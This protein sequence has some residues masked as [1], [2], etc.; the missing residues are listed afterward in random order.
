MKLHSLRIENLR[1]FCDE[2]I[3]F[4]DYT[5]F[6]GANGSGKSTVLT[7]LNIFFREKAG[8]ATNLTQLHRE[9]F[10]AQ[11]T[12]KPIRITLTFV[13]LSA[14]A[15]ADFDAYVRQ[16]KLVV[17]AEA[18]WDASLGYAEVRQVGERM[19]IPQF[20]E[21][22]LAVARNAKKAELEAAYITS[23][24]SVG[25]TKPYG[26]KDKAVETLNAYEASRPE[27]CKPIPSPTDF[28]GYTGGEYLLNKYL[29]WV[30]V[31]AVKDAAEEEAEAKD[32]S[33]SR[34]LQR[35]AGGK[36]TF[37]TDLPALRE[38]MRAEYDGIVTKNQQHL[39]G[40]SRALRQRIQKWAHPGAS[41]SVGFEPNEKS[42]QVSK[43]PAL[44]KAGESGFSGAVS[45]FGHG[46]QRCFLI[47]I[48]QELATASGGSGPRLILGIEEPELYQHPPQARHLADVLRELSQGNTQIVA[49]THSPH[50]ISGSD[51]KS[52]RLV[53]RRPNRTDACVTAVDID[54]IGAVLSAARGKPEGRP[55]AVLAK[56]GQS[57]QPSL[58]EMFFTPVAVFVEGLEDVAYITAYLGVTNQ[59]DAFR[60][61]GCH[62]IPTDK[63]SRMMHPLAIAKQLDIP[64]FV[65]F[66]AD[67]N[68]MKPEPR[69][70]AENDN[71]ALL[72]LLGYKGEDP[73]PQATLWKADLVMWAESITSVVRSEMGGGPAYLA[74]EEEVKRL[75]D[76][77]GSGD[78][79]KNSV[80]IGYTVGE[81]YLRGHRSP[82]L[83][84]LLES[85]ITFAQSKSAAAANDADVPQVGDADAPRKNDVA[86]QVRN[87][88]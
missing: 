24:N 20:S 5:S 58:N 37:D 87:S 26:S 50:F 41:M 7:A 15:F 79:G 61:L 67:A 31:P 53:R 54:A 18:T 2:T 47:A 1:A 48:L 28:Y 9:D 27:L 55:P 39:D 80:V 11:D 51:F 59:L 42:L 86:S 29:L 21:F 77:N 25:I 35:A 52:V 6:V 3:Y 82:S 43:P 30:Y 38:R 45:R 44:I 65:V 76:L 34:L 36:L 14:E 13:D 75:Y 23:I 64:V 40:L 72:E 71:R 78:M 17:T 84:R 4:D 60:R 10:H 69:R 19:G 74:I 63:K 57:L 56:I 66:D 12:S 70:Q 62:L 81:A 33:L 16:G 22:Y 83:E 85:V 49:S 32:S 88:T 68:I 73:M 46:L 8:A